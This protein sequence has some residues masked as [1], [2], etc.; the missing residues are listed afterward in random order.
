MVPDAIRRA[1]EAAVSLNIDKVDDVIEM[2]ESFRW[3]SWCNVALHALRAPLTTTGSQLMDVLMR[4]T[5]K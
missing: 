1:A 5:S 3:M 2:V 4:M